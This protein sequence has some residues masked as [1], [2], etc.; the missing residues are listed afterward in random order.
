MTSL[1]VAIL[2]LLLIL[3]LVHFL[4]NA[5]PGLAGYRTIIMAVVLLV[6][7]IYILRGVALP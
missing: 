3:V 4:C 7:V 1:L 5:L 6:G 2:I